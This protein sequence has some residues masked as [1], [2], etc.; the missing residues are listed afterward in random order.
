MIDKQNGSLVIGMQLT[1]RESLPELQGPVPTWEPAALLLT[2]L[3]LLC[4]L[5]RLSSAPVQLPQ[6]L[7]HQSQR[8][9]AAVPAPS[10]VDPH[11]PTSKVCRTACLAFGFA[12]NNKKL[13]CDLH[14]DIQ[15]I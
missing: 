12:N 11:Q 4:Q 14:D 3:E 2:S 15:S 6:W 9:A 1:M 8:V 5:Q 7:L 10:A 13:I